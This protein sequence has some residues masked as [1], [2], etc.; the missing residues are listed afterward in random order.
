[1]EKER[2]EETEVQDVCCQRVSMW[3]REVVAMKSHQYGSSIR[4]Q[5]M[6][7]LVNIPRQMG[8]INKVSLL[9]KNLLAISGY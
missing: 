5:I 6:K 9:D 1:M 3:Y 8:E 7:T 2:L 4:T